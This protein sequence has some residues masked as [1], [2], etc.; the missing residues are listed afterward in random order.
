MAIRKENYVS[1]LVSQGSIMFL[2][3]RYA[4]LIKVHVVLR[5]SPHIDMELSGR[6]M[7]RNDRGLHRVP[8]RKRVFCDLRDRP[9]QSLI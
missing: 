9:F 8:K 4:S 6:E 7:P 3:P 1:F 2:W 5:A